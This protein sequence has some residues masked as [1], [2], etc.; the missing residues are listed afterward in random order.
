M[1]FKILNGYLKKH[2]HNTERIQFDGGKSF[3]HQ[4][5]IT[6]PQNTSGNILITRALLDKYMCGYKLRLLE[7]FSPS[8]FNAHPEKDK[9]LNEIHTD[10]LTTT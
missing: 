2:L 8:C 7:C 3:F 10:V 9:V 4:V 6:I 1:V 5:H